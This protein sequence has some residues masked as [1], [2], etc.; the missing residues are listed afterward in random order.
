MFEAEGVAGPQRLGPGEFVFAP[1][2]RR[3]GYRNAGTVAAR[4]LVF[5]VPGTGLDRMFAAFAAAGKRAGHR[6]ALETIAAIAKQYGVV[7]H[8]P[9][10]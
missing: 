7:I 10:G 5:A 6:P 3:H 2:N 9:D 1:R 4:L 8:L